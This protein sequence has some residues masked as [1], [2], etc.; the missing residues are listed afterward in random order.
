MNNFD[1]LYT[2]ELK[3]LFQKKIVW[4][5]LVIM[6]ALTVIMSLGGIL[7]TAYSLD[8]QQVSAYDFMAMNREMARLHSGRTLDDAL[9]KEMQAA[10]EGYR[11]VTTNTTSDSTTETSI[12]TSS[13]KNAEKYVA[14]HSLVVDILNGDTDAVLTTTAKELY[15][16]RSALIS[17]QLDSQKLSDGEYAYWQAR[18]SEVKTPFVFDYTRGIS[19]LLSEISVI[20]VLLL[21]LTAICL[22][23][24]FSDEHLR[25][26]DQLVLSSR[27]GK[28]Q[29][30][31]AKITAGVTFGVASAI[32]LYAAAAI[33][34]LT[35]Y[36][37]DGLNA[38][39]QLIM[40]TS[41][42]PMTLGQTALIYLG[43]LIVASLLYSVAAM[44]LSELLKSSVSTMAIMVGVTLLTLFLNVPDIYRLP[45]Q[46]YSYFPTQLMTIESL[47]DRRLVSLP[48][49]Y[50]A[51]WQF[52]PIVYLVVAIL[53]TVV[54]H[55][56]YRR[57]QVSGR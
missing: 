31:L 4:I 24:I 6:V 44:F 56:I 27:L 50:L 25:R 7:F 47:W 1:T 3:K 30:Y 14:I 45:S 17:N 37:T 21:L 57:Y 15:E 2:Y 13:T 33:S 20:N 38:A 53:L 32:L 8:G 5:S 40:Q 16:A 10:Y 29:L 41:S 26:T 28:K 51:N 35:V 18:E 22:S 42:W 23:S 39:I 46:I 43:V 36:G 52:G 11:T 9:L 12:S 48:G 55:R 34:A 54:G 49:T 19:T